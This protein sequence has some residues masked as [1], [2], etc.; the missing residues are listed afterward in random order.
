M[1]IIKASG[2]LNKAVVKW[3][4]QPTAYKT[5]AQF[6]TDFSMYHKEYREK[7]AITTP[8]ANNVQKTNDEIGELHSIIHDQNTA[9]NQI[10]DCVDNSA[11]D[12]TSITSSRS[13]V[14]STIVTTQLTTL[15]QGTR[16]YELHWQSMKQD[17]PTM[18]LLDEVVGAD[19]VEEEAL[20]EEIGAVADDAQ[21][22]S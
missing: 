20:E 10:V 21:L 18:T 1:D 3:Q 12:E 19:M 7:L 14:P 11:C 15:Q 9:I 13:N 17:P 5:K 22:A 8:I 16:N 6:I 4:A 2:I